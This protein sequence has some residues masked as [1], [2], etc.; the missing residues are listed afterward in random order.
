MPSVNFPLVVSYD[1]RASAAYA[2]VS[3]DQRRV[4]CYYEIA[5]GAQGQPAQEAALVRRP[6]ATD[7]GQAYGAAGQVPYLIATDPSTLWATPESWIIAK[8]ASNNIAAHSKAASTTILTSAD[9]VPRFVRQV[10]M[11]GTDY[12]IL[13]C[14]NITTPEGPP[15][16]RV[17]Y[18]STIGTWTEI[19]DG[20][21]TGLKLRGMMEFMDGFAFIATGDDGRLFQN[22]VNTLAA[23]SPADYLSK[24]ITYDICQ[25]LMQVRNQIIFAG[26]ETLE[27]FTNQGNASG[28]VLSRIPYAVHRVGLAAPAGADGILS[29]KT[30]Y[31]TQLGNLIFFPGRLGGAKESVNI[32]AYDGSSFSKISTT[33]EDKILSSTDIYGMYKLSILGKTGIAVQLTAPGAA[34]HKALVF[35]PD[36]QDWFE[37]ES[38]VFSTTNDGPHFLGVTT[39]TKVYHFPATN[40]WQDAGTSFDMTVQFRLPRQDDTRVT[41]NKAGVV[42]DT[43]SGQSLNVQFSDDDGVTWSTARA[44][45]LGVETKNLRN[46][47]TFRSRMVR[48]VHS[49]SGEVRLRRFYAN[50]RQAAS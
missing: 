6:G 27:V 26:R 8:D 31:Y 42:G 19:S 30:H 45:D 36:I 18:S 4:N 34:T 37:W 2:A 41:M 14:Q 22:N 9:Y 17:F 20:D 16:Q 3:R 25:G 10:N 28:S 47:G 50:M 40:N 33:Y 11:D 13:Q 15:S 24:S 43:L 49:G 5:R 32:F 29:G 12:V 46:C 7:Y 35:F 38:T 23:W 44:I 48:L 39:P 1:T 21:F